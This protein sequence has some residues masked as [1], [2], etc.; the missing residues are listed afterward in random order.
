MKLNLGS[1]ENK[2]DGYENLDIKNG[3]E[4]S[5][6][7]QYSDNSLD[8]I[9]ASHVLEHFSH[10]QIYQ[11]LQGWVNK[12]KVGGI[13]K[14]AVPDFAKIAAGYVKGINLNYA[15]YLMGGQTDKDDYHKAI[16]DRKGLVGA[17][18]ALGLENITEWQSEIEDCASLPISLNLQGVK[19]YKHKES[20]VP[21]KNQTND[22]LDYI[23]TKS[24]NIY[25][26]NGED[27]VIEA[28]FEKIGTKNK[29]CLEVGAADGIMFSNTRA[30]VEKGWNAILIESDKAIFDRLTENCKQYPNVQC[31][32]AEIQ[33]SG[34]DSLDTILTSCRAPEDI[35]LVCIDIDG[36]DWHVWN[37]MIE[38]KP[39]VVMVEFC[40]EVDNEDF[41]PTVTGKGQAGLEAVRKLCSSKGYHSCVITDTNLIAINDY[42][43][44][45]KTLQTESVE[46][47]KTYN[48]KAVMSMPRL[49]FADNIFSAMGALVPLGIPIE[50]G[51]GVFWGQVLTRLMESH[52]NDAT[53][54][55]ITIDYDT[56]FTKDQVVR[57][58]NLMHA[59]PEYDAICPLQMKREEDSP[60]FG[61]KNTDGTRAEAIQIP[62]KEDLVSITSG[63][64]GLS[65]FRVESLKKLKKPWFV[66]VPDS[67][68]GWGDGR[69]DEDIWFW[70]NFCD[71]GL[72][73]GM[74]HKIGIG[75]LQLLTTFPGKPQDQY[76]PVHL[77]NNDV[78][79]KGM[80]N[81]CKGDN[82]EN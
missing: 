55:I 35:D 20:I 57:L 13:L 23:K 73:L 41:I 76:K 66:G 54:L 9:R 80:P 31:V 11:I 6:L 15:G 17:F 82:F 32:H 22:I 7:V 36:Q 51:I 21:T 16:F 19:K 29:W 81:W 67:D 50:R 43:V 40:P 69:M 12:L 28:I 30:L 5:D 53:D 25:S 37:Q 72:K 4:V 60:L 38:F 79:I 75:H 26:Q 52:L 49:C 56:Y 71:S 46:T 47:K 3:N 64:F 70:K 77:Y 10:N 65:I 18:E 34:I 1:G 44:V 24:K 33:P 2:L 27:G 14:I 59:H 63:H 62:L 78:Q 61:K 68:G 8:E 39:R 58:I 45:G 48:I 42:C 74:A